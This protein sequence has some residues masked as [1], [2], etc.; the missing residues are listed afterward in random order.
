[1]PKD[2]VTTMK[3]NLIFNSFTKPIPPVRRDIQMVPVQT[4]GDFYLYFYDALRYSNPDF[5]LNRQIEPIL[6]LLNGH[7]SVEQIR[8][9][10]GRSIKKDDLLKFIQML[11]QELLLETD[12]YKNHARLIEGNF[13]KQS[14]RQ[15][16]F[17]GSSYPAEGDEMAVYVKNIIDNTNQLPDYSP[18]KA[19]FAPHIDTEIGAESYAKAFSTLRNLKPKR[20]VILATSH[21]SGY[22]PDLYT[23]KPF[24]GSRKTFL[25]PAGNLKTDETYLD[26]LALHSESA[27]YTENDRA[28]R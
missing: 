12:Y 23:N 14:V 24:I 16:I 9:M 10:M 6:S 20:V 27:G 8:N 21:Y 28:H 22:Y 17:A 18:R 26:Q 3:S 19:I 7:L 4:N 5:A 15:P 2:E 13:E 25:S 1:M 11:D